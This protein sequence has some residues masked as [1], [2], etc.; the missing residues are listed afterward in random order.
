MFRAGRFQ[1]PT[2]S[3]GFA[4]LRLRFNVEVISLESSSLFAIQPS[5]PSAESPERRVSPNAGSVRTPGQSERRV[6]QL[7]AR[8]DMVRSHASH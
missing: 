7:P 1:S 5:R 4:T 8:S 6:R 2:L 3:S